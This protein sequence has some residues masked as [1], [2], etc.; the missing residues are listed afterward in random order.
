MSIKA[1][2]EHRITD[3]DVFS[4]IHW[5]TLNKFLFKKVVIPQMNK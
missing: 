2:N 3:G 4:G 5:N 1:Y